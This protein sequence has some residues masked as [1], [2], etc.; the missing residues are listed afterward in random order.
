MQLTVSMM[1]GLAHSRHRSRSGDTS[2]KCS[3]SGMALGYNTA[4]AEGGYTG[5]SG[6]S[7]FGDIDLE[8]NL[9]SKPL[10]SSYKSYY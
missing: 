4:S 3:E 7:F 10:L 8:V 2:M 9:N 5:G 1:C 6:L